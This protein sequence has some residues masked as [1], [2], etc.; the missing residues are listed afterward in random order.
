M[1]A[2]SKSG[3]NPH[4]QRDLERRWRCKIDVNKNWELKGRL[5]LT[6]KPRKS[7]NLNLQQREPQK[8]F[9]PKESWKNPA[10]FQ[11]PQKAGKIGGL[12]G[13]H[14]EW[15]Q[16]PQILSL[17]SCSQ[18][19]VP[20]PTLPLPP[21]T[22]SLERFKETDFGLWTAEGRWRALLQKGNVGESLH[23]EQWGPQLFL[24]LGG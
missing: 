3:S 14:C 19:T 21:K 5:Q 13:R 4:G 17:T 12:V 6:L 11:A 24:H 22:A 10:E 18:M 1:Q 8:L 9:S 16:D 23:P 2:R 15:H 20:L 7:W